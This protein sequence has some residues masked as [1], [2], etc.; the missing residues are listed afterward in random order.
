MSRTGSGR[1]FRAICRARA[2]TAE[3]PPGAASRRATKPV[4]TRPSWRARACAIKA[5]ASRAAAAH[6]ETDHLAETQRRNA[7]RRGARSGTRRRRG[8]QL[9]P[10]DSP[11][12]SANWR[13][14]RGPSAA[15]RC[16]PRKRGSAPHSRRR[17][18]RP[19]RIRAKPPPRCAGRAKGYRDEETPADRRPKRAER[20]TAHWRPP[21]PR[22]AASA[23][24]HRRSRQR[25][26]RR[27]RGQRRPIAPDC[28]NRAVPRPARWSVW[29]E[30]PAG[31]RRRPYATAG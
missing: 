14:P 13:H 8:S 16:P 15:S 23:G 20:P 30:R 7:E 6:V 2:T 28:R 18:D 31:R 17:R 24:S 22:R 26:W 3:K 27:R 4:P 19:N 21:R 1:R 25:R 9:R 5:N 29:P 11:V 10:R 12:P